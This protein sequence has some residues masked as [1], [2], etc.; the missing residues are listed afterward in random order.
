[1][2]NIIL[3]TLCLGVM[4]LFSAEAL[5]QFGACC[6]SH[7]GVCGC[8]N[9]GVVCCDGFTGSSCPCE[10]EQQ[11][12]RVPGEK[13]PIKV[14][15][16]ATATVLP[17]RPGQVLE[18]KTVPAHKHSAFLPRKEL[19]PGDVRSSSLTEICTSGYVQSLPRATES[20]KSEAYR[21][22]GI[23]NRAGYEIDHLIS[24]GTGGSSE[25]PNLWPQK[26][27]GAWN[28]SHKD[29]LENHLNSLVCSG[30]LKLKEAQEM[31]RS[32]WVAAYRRFLGEPETPK[33]QAKAKKSTDKNKK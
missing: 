29:R 10:D 7:G 18:K 2:R 6:A 33:K 17:D 25:I 22:Y 32:D 21:L 16:I 24:K 8:K 23:T 4:Q 14:L 3:A 20:N 19:T 31:L 13:D 28:M 30:K 5:A 26:R 15:P 27:A 1:M 12:I 11:E 9:G